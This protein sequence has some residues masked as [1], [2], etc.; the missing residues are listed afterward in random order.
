MKEVIE[1]SAIK[2]AVNRISVPDDY[3][4]CT[5]CGEFHPQD[6]YSDPIKLEEMKKSGYEGY[7]TRT[8]CYNCYSSSDMNAIS[9]ARKKFVF[10]NAELIAKTSK[11]LNDE[12]YYNDGFLR[13]D[14]VSVA[15][16]IETLKSMDPTARV[17]IA[18]YDKEYG[19]FQ[20]Y[21]KPIFAYKELANNRIL[22]ISA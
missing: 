14:S 11:E 5:V 6:S 18:I 9:E 19:D 22:T 12:N 2:M 21:E 15:E 20:S 8:N 17:A 7:R 4:Q 10:D 3:V 13:Y 1:V 16:M